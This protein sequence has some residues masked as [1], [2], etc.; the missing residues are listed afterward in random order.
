MVTT[1]QRGARSRARKPGRRPRLKPPPPP[2]PAAP[3]PVNAAA[4]GRDAATGRFTAGN[5]AGKGNPHNRQV[6]R[7]KSAL[8][9]AVSEEDM[10]RLGAQLLAQ[11]LAGDT[12]AAKLLLAYTLGKPARATDPDRVDLD[13]LRLYEEFPDTGV[14]D[15]ALKCKL[16]AADAARFVRAVLMVFSPAY[17]KRLAEMLRAGEVG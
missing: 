3:A 4:D 5:T 16:D 17:F 6:G 12:A 1:F 15:R 10:H 9:S 7:L 11:A 8:L 2:R 13:E 14:I